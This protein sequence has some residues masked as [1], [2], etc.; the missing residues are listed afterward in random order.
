LEVLAMYLIKNKNTNAVLKW[1][2]FCIGNISQFM[3]VD[4]NDPA[5]NPVIG[6]TKNYL[7]NLMKT[8]ALWVNESDIKNCE[9]IKDIK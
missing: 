6:K 9:I 4:N 2:L 1:K 5:L 3:V 8:P 7:K